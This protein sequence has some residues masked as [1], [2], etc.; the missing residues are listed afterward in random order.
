MM[1]LLHLET[2][3][4]SFGRRLTVRVFEQTP[5]FCFEQMK[6]MEVERLL[7]F[8]ELEVVFEPFRCWSLK[9]RNHVE[10]SR[11][12][13]PKSTRLSLKGHLT[14]YQEWLKLGLVGSVELVWISCFRFDVLSGVLKSCT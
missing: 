11:S 12:F 13:G 3:E 7:G 2:S 4:L 6:V 8:V 9:E 10:Y 1:T 14:G 5:K